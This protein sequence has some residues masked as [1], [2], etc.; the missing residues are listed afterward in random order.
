MF[1]APN[2]PSSTIPQFRHWRDEDGRVQIQD[3]N[4]IVQMLC[5]AY[6][7]YPVTEDTSQ[8]YIEVL[9]ERD[10]EPTMA[11]VKK[12]IMRESFF[13]RINE[14]LIVIRSETRPTP[15]M[16]ALP[17]GPRMSVDELRRRRDEGIRRG[18][19]ETTQRQRDRS[20]RTG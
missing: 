1:F 17:P 11:A 18:R 16:P 7:T 3:A 4:A 19:D 20:E 8:L 13:P 12:W 14:L 5:A 6:P 10:A 9:C 2:A 15:P